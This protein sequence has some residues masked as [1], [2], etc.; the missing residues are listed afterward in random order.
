MKKSHMLPQTR[1]LV[2]KDVFGNDTDLVFTLISADNSAFTKLAKAYGQRMM[3][4]PDTISLDEADQANC[5]ML[6]TCVVG[7]TGWEDDEGNPIP[8]SQEEALDFMGNPGLKYVRDQVEGY[9]MKRTQF[10]RSSQEHPGSVGSTE[11]P[12]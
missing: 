6:A 10:F 1:D 7:W 12:A 5:E 11:H 3:K 2:I 9:V 8:H 4:N